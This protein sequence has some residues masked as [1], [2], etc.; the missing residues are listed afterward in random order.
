MTEDAEKKARPVP[1]AIKKAVEDELERLVGFGPLKPI[2]HSRYATPIVPVMKKMGKCLT[3]SYDYSI[4]Y[5]PGK[6]VGHADALSRM[7]LKS[8]ENTTEEIPVILI[9][10]DDMPPISAKEIPDQ[11]IIVFCGDIE[12]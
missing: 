10:M 2:A 9:D 1:F 4:E 6:G 12:L 8:T 7:P 3:L 11:R 5:R